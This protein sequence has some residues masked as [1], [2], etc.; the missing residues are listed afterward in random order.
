M[1][2]CEIW[3]SLG[4]LTQH[5]KNFGKP[6]LHVVPKFICWYVCT[7]CLENAGH[8]IQPGGGKRKKGSALALTRPSKGDAL[9]YPETQA[10]EG[11]SEG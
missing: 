4:E 7:P 5:R 9:H 10:T 6:D 1:E 8:Q 2:F 11:V 3:F